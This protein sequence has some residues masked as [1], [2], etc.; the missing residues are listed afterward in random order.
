MAAYC[1]IKDIN[2]GKV[3]PYHLQGMSTNIYFHINMRTVFI[4]KQ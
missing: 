2:G 3:V 1:D 4:G